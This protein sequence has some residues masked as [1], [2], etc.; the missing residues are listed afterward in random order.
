MGYG[1]ALQALVTDALSNPVPGIAVTFNLPAAQPAG[2]F[3]NSQVSAIVNTD[4]HGVAVSP[5]FRQR[6]PPDR[7][8]RLPQPALSTRPSI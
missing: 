2:T 3:P 7:R 8:L 1:N 6:C 5:R 4:V